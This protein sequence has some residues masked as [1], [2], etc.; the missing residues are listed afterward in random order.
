MRAFLGSNYLF[1]RT[2]GLAGGFCTR[3][4]CQGYSLACEIRMQIL[5]NTDCTGKT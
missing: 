4:S 1:A 3:I 2:T 5:G